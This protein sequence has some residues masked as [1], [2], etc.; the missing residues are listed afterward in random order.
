V[1]LTKTY[2]EH[3]RGGS[4]PG[5]HRVIGKVRPDGSRTKPFIT[6]MRECNSIALLHTDVVV[7]IGAYVG[8]Y[9]IRAARFPVAKVI[10][11]EPTPASF[12]I[13]TET[14]LPN[15]QTVQ[16]AVV[17]DDETSVDLFISNGIGV[18]NST[19]A[20]AGKGKTI[21]VPAVS[22]VDA[23]AD[24]SIVKID[25]EGGEY[26]YPIVQPLLRAVMIDFHPLPDFDWLRESLRIIEELEDNGFRAVIAPDFNASG[27]DRAGSWIRDVPELARATYAPMLDGDECCGC[28]IAINAKGKGL[29]YSCWQLWSPKHRKGFNV[30]NANERER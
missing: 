8:T 27:W 15:L 30:D 7:D 17:A 28:G 9:A 6:N 2:V 23:V 3:V 26:Q 12:D 19:V 14:K 5:G 29:C 4:V 18:T 13:L 16:A 24:A 1:K 11:Y 20:D 10:A 25:V 22:Y 21:S